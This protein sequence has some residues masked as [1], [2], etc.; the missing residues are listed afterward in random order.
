MVRLT[1]PYFFPEFLKP[2]GKASPTAR[3]RT[4]GL[5]AKDLDWLYN[6]YLA[7]DESRQ[8]TSRHDHPMR[9]EK[10]LINISGKPPHPPCRRVR[11]QPDTRRRQGVALHPG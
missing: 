2:Q 4:L 5:T 8:D 1:P 6:L 10:V 9:V 7:T 3:E 11:D